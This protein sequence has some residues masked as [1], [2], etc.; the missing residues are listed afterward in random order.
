MHKEYIEKNSRKFNG[1]YAFNKRRSAITV[2]KSGFKPCLRLRYNFTIFN[3][4][5]KP[6]MLKTLLKIN[7]NVLATL[8][9][10][11]LV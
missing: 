1:S 7:L 2:I 6:L 5:I 3:A 9:F 8:K 10:V 4:Q 11:N